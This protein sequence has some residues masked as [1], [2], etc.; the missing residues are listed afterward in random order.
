M[1]KQYFRHIQV[2][3]DVKDR[4]P[5]QVFS[6]PGVVYPHCGEDGY[7]NGFCDQDTARASLLRSWAHQLRYLSYMNLKSLDIKFI[8]RDIPSFCCRMPAALQFFD[9]LLE[10]LAQDDVDMPDAEDNDRTLDDHLLDETDRA[11]SQ[12]FGAQSTKVA[13]RGFI[14]DI[15]LEPVCSTCV[16]KARTCSE[17]S[18][19]DEESVL[20][21]LTTFRLPYDLSG[22][23]DEIRMHVDLKFDGYNTSGNL[24]EDFYNDDEIT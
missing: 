16:A 2:T 5:D 7:E 3:I 6:R 19:N 24:E 4:H 11:P 17:K 23:I 15:R 18:L 22:K 20:N 14:R 13:F 9:A 10:P 8:C 1:N 21:L 12:E